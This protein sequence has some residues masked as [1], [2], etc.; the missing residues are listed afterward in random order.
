M[1]VNIG[2]GATPTPGWANLDN[3]LTVAAARLPP[4]V[5]HG[6]A[7]AGLL[8]GASLELAALARSAP[9]GYANAARRIPYPD[10]S[11]EVVYS[12]H[13]IEHLDRREARGFLREVRRVLR[14][15]GVVRLTA[16]D[17]ALQVRGY[18]AT[19]DADEFVAGTHMTQDRP[20]R[21]LPR[22]RTAV[23]GPRQHLWMYDGESLRRLLAGMGFT[24]VTVLPPGETRIA[25]PGSLDLKERADESV[26]AEAVSP[27]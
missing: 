21:L 25:D 3:S 27:G 17:L 13:M 5:L 4:R 8:P 24:D 9:I 18:L 19:A 12:A 2:C 14:P 1:R 15:G 16:P 20:S 7:K 22:L 11:V 6:L 26:Y 10:D 23:T